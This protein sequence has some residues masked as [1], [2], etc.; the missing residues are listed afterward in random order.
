MTGAERPAGH[1]GFGRRARPVMA[2]LVLFL[3]AGAGRAGAPPRLDFYRGVALAEIHPGHP[4]SAYREALGEIRRLGADQVLLPV[5]GYVD[6]ASAPALSA[7]WEPPCDLATYRTFVAGLAREAHRQDLEVLL[8]PY[9]NLRADADREWRGTLRPPDWPAWFRSYEAFLN[10]WVDL[11]IQEKIEM[12][13]VGAELVSSER[14]TALWRGLIE[15][16]RRRYHGVILY[17]F[18][19][20]HYRPAAFHDALDYVGLSGYYS[21]PTGAPL[22]ES[23]VEENWR[24]V[25]DELLAFSHEVDRRILFTEIGYPSVAGGARDPWNYLMTGPADAPGQARALSAFSRVWHRPPEL[26]GVFFWNWSPFRGG[27]DDRSYSLNGKP[28]ASVVR[29]WFATV[30]GPAGPG[31]Q[32]GDH[33]SR[34]GHP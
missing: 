5:Y 21:L 33:D 24:E 26:A 4:A 15:R 12:L 30:G 23:A 2:L 11:A 22:T 20:D 27:W 14:Q 29:A 28:A 19:W 6:S 1:R 7:D 18:N 13:A 9:V 16:V 8:I 31:R 3:T 34:T 10:G 32:E 25:R 17:S